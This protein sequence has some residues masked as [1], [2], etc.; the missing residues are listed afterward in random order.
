MKPV[1]MRKIKVEYTASMTEQEYKGI[2]KLGREWG[3][4]FDN[5]KPLQ[6]AKRALHDSGVSGCLSN[7][8][9]PARYPGDGRWHR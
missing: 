7:P 4:D 3:L 9:N 5:A 8:P 2:V 6:I 1:K